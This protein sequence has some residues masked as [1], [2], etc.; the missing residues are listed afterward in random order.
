[1]AIT[2]LI[3]AIELGSSKISGIAGKKNEDDSLQV[4]AYTKVDSSSFIKKG[5]VYNLEQTS[6]AIKTIVQ[7]LEATLQSKIAKVYV[8]IGGQS[9]RT[10]K[11]VINRNLGDQQVL[12]SQER[13]DSVCDE[14]I[15]L[16]ITNGRTILEVSP[17]EFKIGNDYSIDPVGIAGKQIEGHFMNIVAQETLKSSLEHSFKLAE[18]EIADLLVSPLATANLLLSESDKKAGCALVD[19]GA[20]TTTVSVYKNELLRFLSVIPLGGDNI[21]RDL[22]SFKIDKERAEYL[23][24]K[25]ADLNYTLNESEEEED[26]ETCFLDKEKTRKVPLLDINNI[27]KARAEE[28]I[29]NVWNQIQLSG[30]HDEL[31]AGIT[32]TG[33]ASNLVGLKDLIQ[34]TTRIN[35][36]KIG[37]T[38]KEII[39]SKLVKE[40][41]DQEAPNSL[42]TL[43]GLLSM[44][45][46]NCAKV[47]KVTDRKLFEGEEFIEKQ[48]KTPEEILKEQLLAKKEA[49]EKE[50]R[51][52]KR[53][54]EEEKA[55]RKKKNKGFLHKSMRK[56]EQF[57]KN[58]FNEDNPTNKD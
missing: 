30:Y 48:E 5:V 56:I 32:I 29:A 37:N 1:M 39:H 40:L 42:F 12:I 31:N 41:K 52:R 8:G 27:I 4:L 33:G 3:A 35:R 50:R 44:G 21:T 58:L 15:E 26:E 54:E 28:I 9:V 18:V 49:E 23:K 46:M 2:E 10:L 55:K 38:H 36:I 57:Q 6:Q 53:K 16:P 25:V 19:F 47:E 43:I 20:E 17:Q 11:N 24:L 22:T 14:N 45:D 13:V 51:E 34:K 7:G